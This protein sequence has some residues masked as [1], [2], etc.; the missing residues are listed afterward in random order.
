MV[1]PAAFELHSILMR[2]AP[3][4]FDDAI[5]FAP[6]TSG[7]YVDETISQLSFRLRKYV[8]GRL[9]T[10]DVT[11]SKLVL[12]EAG[13][14]GRFHK[15]QVVET[16]LENALLSFRHTLGHPP[17]THSQAMRYAG[18]VCK[19]R[20]YPHEVHLVA[21]PVIDFCIREVLTSDIA[22]NTIAQPCEHYVNA[23]NGRY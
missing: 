8:N 2:A 4:G 19:V 20:R 13:H 11:I 6:M 1:G 15:R 5:Y 16:I 7:L 18:R 12:E 14:A 17:M 10:Q 3:F 9:H 22:F 21:E 23:R